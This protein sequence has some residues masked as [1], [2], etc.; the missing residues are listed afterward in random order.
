MVVIMLTGNYNFFNFLF[1]GL[2]L[3]LADDSWLSSDLQKTSAKSH[4]IFYCAW[5]LFHLT[6][7]AGLVWAILVSFKDA[8]PGRWPTLVL[9]SLL[10]A[11]LFTLSLPSYAGQLDRRTYDAIPSQVKLWHRKLSPLELHHSYGLFRS[12]TGIGGRPEVVLEGADTLE[13]PWTEYHFLYRPGNTSWA[14]RF[15]LPHQPRLDWQM[16][17]AAL[18][19][20]NHNPW[21]L[22]LV[23]RLLE[24][25]AEVLE[26]LHPDTVWVARSPPLY[27]RA[28]L[29]T[30]TFT[31][32]ADTQHWWSRERQRLYLPE[33]SLDNKQLVE[34]LRSEGLIT[35]AREEAVETP[36][37]VAGLLAAVRRVSKLAPTELQIWTC[38]WLAL[39]M[40]KPFL[41]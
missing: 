30:Y 25:R 27:I 24:G 31:D 14:P 38:A 39:P 12:M 36:G 37:L 9:Y 32:Q 7:C 34:I 17:F 2:C 8:S 16:W 18:G 33:L 26:L 15:V 5:C 19:S 41:L 10:A 28:Q 3:S 20:Y 1:M 23:Y 4:P 11:G 40:F 13:G 29:Y 6:V 21:L 22:S 35:E